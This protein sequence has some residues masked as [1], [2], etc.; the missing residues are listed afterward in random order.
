M[1]SAREWLAAKGLAKPGARGRF[2]LDA[3]AALNKAVSDGIEFSDWPKVGSIPSAPRPKLAKAVSRAVEESPEEVN[4]RIGPIYPED[5]FG[6]RNDRGKWISVTGRT[7][8][9]EHG[10]SISY[11]QCATREVL[12]ADMQVR[13]VVQ[14]GA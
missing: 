6:Y 8:C 5:S 14:N 13:Q 12:C 4:I 7:C 2:S 10:Y 11:H 9:R 1:T 3:K